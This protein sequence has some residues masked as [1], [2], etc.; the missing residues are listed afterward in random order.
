MDDAR[1]NQTRPAPFHRGELQAQERAG[2]RAQME[3]IGSIVLRDYMPD[4]HREFF[5]LLP[6]FFIGG[7]DE[8]G[9]IWASVLWGAPGFVQS[10]DPT[11]LRIAARLPEEDPLAAVLR[12]GTGLGGLGLQFETRRR[13]RANGVVAD[14]DAHGF[15]LKVQQ[16]FGNCPK[17]IQTREQRAWAPVMADVPA[18]AGGRQLPE[19]ALAL[20][21][22]ADTFFIATAADEERGVSHGADVSHR[23]GRPGFVAIDAEGAMIWPDFQGNNFFNTIGNL[24]ADARAGLLFLDFASGDLLQ[25]SGR[26]EVVWDGETVARFAGAKRLLRFLPERHVFRPGRMPLRWSLSEVSPHLAATGT[27]AAVEKA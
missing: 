2:V 8:A 1:T 20:I 4:Q 3:K 25:L 5:P 23:G 15:T 21:R 10:P 26:A 19:A 6:T 24:L 13:N 18:V 11:T 27:W 17:Y 9:R 22:Q 16:S 14:V 12:P 7:S